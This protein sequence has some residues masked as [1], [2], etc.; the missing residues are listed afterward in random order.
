M[1]LPTTCEGWAT[2]VSAFVKA[3]T[4][5]LNVPRFP[6]RIDAVAREYSRNMFPKEP[7]TIVQGGR[8]DTFEGAL[9]PNLRGL[10]IG[11]FSTMLR[12]FHRAGSI[13]LA[14]ELDIIY[15]GD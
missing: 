13:H 14:H 5:A 15:T 11:E 7:I 2:R 3:A 9:V 8:F 10:G 6:I 12:S 4:E 1:K